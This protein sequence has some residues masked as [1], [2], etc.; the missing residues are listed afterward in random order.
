M[1]GRF[2]LYSDKKEIEQHF[3]VSFTDDVPYEPGYN[4]A[5]GSI[6]PVILTKGTRDRVVEPLV[7]GYIPSF[8]KDKQAQSPLIN[9]RSETI[10]EKP[11]FR[12]SF[13]RRRCI[14][15]S[16]GFFEWKEVGSKKV[17]FYIR[18]LEEPLFG[19]A[20]I[21]DT[22]TN[23]RGKELTTFAILTT[24]AN[25]LI[26]PLHH[27]MPVLLRP[28][29]YDVWLDPVTKEQDRLP[30]LFKPHPTPGMSLYRV[31]EEVN[32]PSNNTP[33]LIQPK[34]K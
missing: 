9:A 8:A 21:F 12:Q 31:N 32:N 23:D 2:T 10:H 18:L 27:R 15:P 19:M 17:P 3:H 28:S 24:S 4:I 25:D 11:S 13:Q 14:I 29:D 7:W 6:Q 30:A 16:N 34:L 1:C 20:G 5:P 26:E 33:D 22:Y